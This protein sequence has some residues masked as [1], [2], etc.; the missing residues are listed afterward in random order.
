M[1]KKF[2][3]WLMLGLSF[4]MLIIVDLDA[5]GGGRGGRGGGGGGRGGG[6]GSF[7]GSRG[8]GGM[9][10]GGSMSRSRPSHSRPAN[11]GRPSTNQRP[12]NMNRPSAQNRPSKPSQRPNAGSRPN[13]KNLENFLGVQRERPTTRPANRPDGDR[14]GRPG[15]DRPGMPGGDRPGRPGGDR[16]GRP[17]GDRPG[18]P[19][20]RPGQGDRWT[21]RGDQVRRNYHHNNLNNHFH[22]NYWWGRAGWATAIGWAGW[23]WGTPYYYGYSDDGSWGYSDGGSYYDSDSAA[24][25]SEQQDTI[26]ATSDAASVADDEWLPLGVFALT[27]QEG[28]VAEPNGYMQLSL[29]KGGTLTGYYYNSTTDLSYELEGIVDKETQMAAWQ[30]A[31]SENSPIIETGIFNLTEQETPARVHFADGRTQDVLLV[32]LS[33]DNK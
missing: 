19:G 26:S 22:D 21:G 4:S 18:I 6:G 14:P 20:N 25:Y 13:N 27:T 7:G 15:G 30:M 8:G 33:G 32:A 10:R 31:D 24:S 9:N 28:S 23:N 29:S 12:A 11:S 17:G 3:T 5:R 16:P 2:I 1:N